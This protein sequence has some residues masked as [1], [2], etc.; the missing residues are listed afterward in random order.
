MSDQ[1]QHDI[2]TWNGR[3]YTIASDEPWIKLSR[4]WYP[5]EIATREYP[6]RNPLV[7]NSNQFQ[8]YTD[9]L[10]RTVSHVYQ[11]PPADLCVEMLNRMVDM[12]SANLNEGFRQDFI[13][14]FIGEATKNY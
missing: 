14:P 10:W 9:L 12:S 8:C 7:G 2:D 11:L 13:I 3:K 4:A 6:K 5:F 1:L